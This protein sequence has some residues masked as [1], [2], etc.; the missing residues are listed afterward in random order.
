MVVRKSEP[1]W[2][3]WVTRMRDDQVFRLSFWQ[4]AHGLK[5]ADALEAVRAEV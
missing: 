2:T 3:R 5:R 4:V 1:L